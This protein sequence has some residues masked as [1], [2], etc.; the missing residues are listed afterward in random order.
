MSGP[1][2]DGGRGCEDFC[3]RTLLLDLEVAAN[4]GIREIGACLGSGELRIEV[5][6]GGSAG[7]LRRLDAFAEGAEFVLGHNLLRHDL[8]TLRGAAP[9]LRLL[10][11]PVVDTLFLSPLAFP[12]NPYHRLVKDYKLVSA[13][14]NDPVADAR[15]A[16]SVFADQWGAFAGMQSVAPDLLALY[17]SCFES[18]HLGRGGRG[19][20]MA[21]VFAEIGARSI[22]REEAWSI[23][24]EVAR[25]HVCEA[26]LVDVIRDLGGDSFPPPAIAYMAAWLRVA[27]ARSVLPRWVRAEFNEIAATVRKLRDTPCGRPECAYCRDQWDPEAQLNRYFGFA[28]FRAIGGKPLQRDI[29]LAGMGGRPL[30]ALLPTGAGKSLCFQLPALV[31]H[32]RRG[33]LTVVISPLQALL[34]DQ[35][36]GLEMKTGTPHAG[37]IY[38]MLT[39]P[40]RREVL[41]RV[42]LG[43]VA[44]LYVSPEQLR[45][46]SFR[47]TIL[48]REIGAWVFDEAHC[49]SK[50]GHDF[51]PDYFYASRFV[52]EVAEE[53]REGLPPVFCFTATAKPNVIEEILAHF[54][55]NLGQEL[56]VYKGPVERENL[57]FEVHDVTQ[58][59]KLDAVYRLLRDREI[60]N[61]APGAA[62]VYRATR[63]STEDSARY[64]EKHGISAMAFHGGLPAP[65]KRSIQ[66]SFLENRVKVMCATNAFGMGVDKADVR[67]V[68][69]ADIPGSIENYLQEAGRA[70]RDQEPSD[71]IL[72]YDER[73]IETQFR[74]GAYSRITRRDIAGILKG[75]RRAARRQKDEIVLTPGELLC[76]REVETSFE[77]D[78]RSA[79]T[80]VKTAL[81]WLER[82]G[83]LQRDEN[84][85]EVFQGAPLVPS[86]DAGRVL[87]VEKNV[88]PPAAR[89]WLGLLAALLAAD[90]D[91]GLRF[92]DLAGLPAYREFSA[93]GDGDGRALSLLVRKDLH[94]MAEAG[95]IKEGLLFSAYVRPRG[96]RTSKSEF[97]RATSQESYRR[98]VDDL[99][100][101]E[102]AAIVAA[103]RAGN[104]LVLAGPG[105]G[106]TRVV[107]HR[108]A[109]L[110]RVLRVRPEEVL[111][112]C[113]NHNAAVELRTRL[114]GLVDRDARGVT[115]L[116]Y[117]ALAMRLSGSS[118]AERATRA[119]AGEINFDEV[120]KTAVRLLRGEEDIPGVEP[121]EVR[122]RLLSGYRHVLVDEYQDID[123][124]Q[125]ELISAI[126]GRT[127][128]DAEEKLSILAV[129][130]DDQ[131]IYSFRGANVEF[132]KRFEQDYGARRFRLVEN[133]RSTASIID[134]SNRV[135]SANRDRL[136]TSDPIRINEHRAMYA[137][138]GRFER[139]DPL[140]RGRVQRLRVAGPAEEAVAVLAE[141]R[142]LEELGESA[143][144]QDFAVLART[145]MALEPIRALLEHEGVP[146]S[147][148]VD[149][150]KAPPLHRVREISRVLESLGLRAAKFVRAGALLDRLRAFPTYRAGNPW[151]ALLEEL[152]H[153]WRDET[154][155]ARLPA[156]DVSEFLYE[157]LLQRRKDSRI[158]SGVFLGTVH[159][160]KGMEF[161][162]VLIPATGWC[163]TDGP[164][165]TGPRSRGLAGAG[166]RSGR[167]AWGG[168]LDDVVNSVAD[169]SRGPGSPADRLSFTA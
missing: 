145:R 156:G 116:T 4:G 134:V 157:A 97:E 100:N 96:Q 60:G 32:F 77:Y 148:F 5:G 20:G 164:G 31:R 108:C 107:V 124:V 102:Q 18:A 15:L 84:R 57:R 71:C 42:R 33:A 48:A 11:L 135:I 112:L 119:E 92:D 140:A 105:S 34:T 144:W 147:H 24:R 49:I 19:E 149:R 87:L 74:L 153:A 104:M 122:D 40:E 159:V 55:A 80:K 158:G 75:L 44:I 106:K 109:Y 36:D 26:A 43:D 79:E 14:R 73:D 88:A 12:E 2:N 103:P 154:D 121:D 146:R 69:H 163:G 98:I 161:R 130:D 129:G 169:G 78:D 81:S 83:F 25:E 115:V 133:Y 111:V 89:R 7:A 99:R 52:R 110:L 8:P 120:L 143:G 22:G 70:G 125:Y 131:N 126:T 72:L 86:V 28:G 1:R 123:E 56:T 66:E 46:P 38:G 3:A 155:N 85:T 76:D 167:R 152:L 82:A 91:E 54:S 9:A 35:V 17:R 101:P 113:F 30:L 50:W 23:F 162:H 138:G 67:V 118:F 94:E 58:P 127:V 27:G 45:N 165:R 117:H 151:S 65:A 142:R 16:A 37:A 128:N 139:L 39:P 137:A 141:I 90:A 68:I 136:K 168:L 61:G 62:I 53:Q 6:R 21:R 160:A 29:T 59:T 114:A 10:S 64:L 132:L 41:D 47:K 95:L 93:A 166:R 51:R 13:S 63:Q 150:N